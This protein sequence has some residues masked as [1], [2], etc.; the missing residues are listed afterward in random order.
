MLIFCGTDL[1]FG[2]KSKTKNTT[3]SPKQTNHSK[4]NT[5]TQ[6]NLKATQNTILYVNYSLD[7]QVETLF[8]KTEISYTKSMKTNIL[9]IAVFLTTP[10][11]S[12][13]LCTYKNP[14][15]EQEGISAFHVAWY[16]ANKTNKTHKPER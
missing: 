14:V 4:E 13:S 10:Q 3:T 12:G 6:A 8:K 2:S 15:K 11:S 5:S 16:H 9:L 7:W 1:Y